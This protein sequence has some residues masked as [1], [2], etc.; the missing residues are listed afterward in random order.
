MRTFALQRDKNFDSVFVLGAA[1]AKVARLVGEDDN[2]G[3]RGRGVGGCRRRRRRRRN[4][5]HADC[6]HKNTRGG[7]IGLSDVADGHDGARRRRRGERSKS[8]KRHQGEA[9]GPHDLVINPNKE[10]TLWCNCAKDLCFV[11]HRS[12]ADP[13]YSVLPSRL[14]AERES[15]SSLEFTLRN[16]AGAFSDKLHD[17]RQKCNAYQKPANFYC[18]LRRKEGWSAYSL[19]EGRY[20]PGSTSVIP[21][22]PRSLLYQIPINIPTLN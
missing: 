19:T 15:E 21:H 16:F 9:G 5:R 4:L 20:Y 11:R 10:I 7:G 22:F 2:H 12:M 14:Q 17:R 6:F 18:S 3:G 1:H 8:E 13:S